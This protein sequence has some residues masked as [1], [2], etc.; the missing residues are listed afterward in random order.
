V[1][2]VTHAVVDRVARGVR[3]LRELLV[4]GRDRRAWAA[5]VSGAEGEALSQRGKA[6]ERLGKVKRAE[7][8]IFWT[9]PGWDTAARTR[10]GGRG[11]L[12][13]SGEGATG[14]GGVTVDGWLRLGGRELTPPAFAES[15]I[16]ACGRA[17]GCFVPM[18]AFLSRA[19]TKSDGQTWWAP[20][21]A[22]DT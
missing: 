2:Y 20:R 11:G 13:S 18:A 15:L 21:S 9:F 6:M 3:D 14:G 19:I 10:A 5:K 16:E 4:W 17:T 22:R 1:P 8:S 12:V 7:G